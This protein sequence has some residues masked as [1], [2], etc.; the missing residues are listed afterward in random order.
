M[1]LVIAEKPNVSKQLRD[2]FEPHAKYGGAPG[3]F[4]GEKYTFCC[5]LGHLFTFAMP[6][7]INDSYKRYALEDLPL[8]LPN[9]I[10]LKLTN[11][12]TKQ[13]Y[14]VLK[15]VFKTGN[16]DE[17]I[18]A[19][20]PDREGQSIYE[21]IKSQTRNFPKVPESRIWI[22]EWTPSGLI[23]AM[24]NKKPNDNYRGLKAASECRAIEDYLIGMNGSRAMTVKFGGAN[25]VISIGSTQTPTL[26]MIVSR[27]REITNFKAEDYGVPFIELVNDKGELL[28]LKHTS[29]RHLSLLE[30]QTTQK[31]LLQHQGTVVN[32]EEK[33]RTSKPMKLPNAT[34]IQK[35]MNK[36]YGFTADKTSNILQTLY[37]DK[38]LTTYPGTKAREISKSSATLSLNTIKNLLKNNVMPKETEKIL[39]NNWEI[40]RHCIANEGLAHE[41][42]TPVFG[43]INQKD[44]DS[45]TQDERKVY[46]E[47]VKRFV[48]AFFPEAVFSDTIITTT[49]DSENFIAKGSI[50]IQK[51]YKEIMGVGEDNLLP[52]F[53]NGKKYPISKVGIEEKQTTP[54]PR[55]TTSTLLEAMENASRFVDDKH[56]AKI[57]SS[58]EVNGLG[59]DRTRSDILNKLLQ[60]NYYEFKGK[61]IYPTQKAIDLFK[62]LPS[63]GELDSPI[64]KAKMEEKLAL[65]ELGKL[66]KKEYLQE[67]YQDI[68]SFVQ[69]VKDAKQQVIANNMTSSK[70]KCPECGGGLLVSSKVVKCQHCNFILF[71]IVASKK[72]SE[73]NIKD[74]IEKKETKLI[75]SFKSKTGNSFDAK[76]KLV[77]ANDRWAV[78]FDFTKE[79]LGKCPR[80]GGD[81]VEGA[82]GF[83]CENKNCE[84]FIFKDNKLL[85]KSKKKVTFSM[86]KKMLKDNGTGR[87]KVTGLQSSNGQTYSAFFSLDDTGKYINLKMEFK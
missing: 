75:K 47:I 27:E 6:E 85:A 35:E 68:N 15:K 28:T 80:C 19:T 24:N 4:I 81:I 43:Q 70:I 29:K 49:I 84:F 64:H 55:Y 32:I 87:V 7:E 78:Q 51:G 11:D 60:R 83:S 8:N 36:K 38:H 48:Q 13:Y 53:V 63:S 17:I 10:P 26:Y 2:A 25:N 22:S 23:K 50:I 18:V 76:L 52:A 79:V 41:A 42:I 65:V 33:R 73:T 30:A 45:L 1:K 57:L 20:A 34:D 14:S 12:V 59:T 37:Q 69:A 31:K 71:P 9:D 21:R 58:K 66:S 54:P 61:T 44:V 67:V 74:L 46:D 40:A 82:K 39:E 16:F 62:V 86:V 56:Y 77:K 3:Y 5:A 72:L